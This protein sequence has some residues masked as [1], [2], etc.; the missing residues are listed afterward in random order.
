MPVVLQDQVGELSL[1]S[2]LTTCPTEL[3]ISQV[4]PS[5]VSTLVSHVPGLSTVLMLVPVPRIT[6][7]VSLLVSVQVVTDPLDPELVERYT[8]PLDETLGPRISPVFLSRIVIEVSF[9]SLLAHTLIVVVP[10][11]ELPLPSF[12]VSCTVYFPVPL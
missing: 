12:T 6:S 10:I 3:V 11:V 7:P 5:L 2:L 9:P 1:S 8:T 4:V